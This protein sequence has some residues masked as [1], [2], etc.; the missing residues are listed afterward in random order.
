MLGNLYF[1]TRIMNTLSFYI[2][3]FYEDNSKLQI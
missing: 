1:E 3:M 2:I